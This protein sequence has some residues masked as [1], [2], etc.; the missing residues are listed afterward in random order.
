MWRRAAQLSAPRAPANAA[1][2][3]VPLYL[4]GSLLVVLDQL[5]I[6][7]AAIPQAWAAWAI[8]AGLIGMAAI[9]Y[10][11]QRGVPALAWPLIAGVVPTAVIMSASVLSHDDS[12]AAQLTFCWPLL[13][14]AYHLKP[15]FAWVVTVV[16][17]VA[18]ICLC[19]VVGGPSMSEDATAVPV[20]FVAITFILVGACERA[21]GLL[22][23]LRHEAEHDALTGLAARRCFDADL[24][25]LSLPG[26][27]VS[28]LILDVD[29][30]KVINDSFGHS[31]G[32]EVLRSV[33]ARLVL[34]GR[35][36]DTAYRLGGDELAILLP[37]CGL[38]TALA[39]AESI[40]ASVA[41]SL[42][43][44]VLGPSA[45]ERFTVSIGVASNLS[46]GNLLRAADGALYAAKQAGRD[47]VAADDGGSGWLFG[48]TTRPQSEA[49]A[50]E[51][52]ARL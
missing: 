17:V 20:I 3:A 51:A 48:T 27:P 26:V 40:R 9:L 5:V 25:A 10:F 44:E 2:A 37:G 4:A 46:K 36:T 1:R 34:G 19:L 29:H 6:P 7:G 13:F 39:R 38:P 31:V 12:A 33:A 50:V 18:D 52:A 11:G 43:S 21:D 22:V 35:S 8:V 30:F 24:D 14:A 47:T 41:A 28:L 15:T 42:A 23:K 45:Q 32:D 16:V 49:R